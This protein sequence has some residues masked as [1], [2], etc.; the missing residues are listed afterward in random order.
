[1]PPRKG[2]KSSKP[3]RRRNASP[4]VDYK[5]VGV[6]NHLKPN[7]HFTIQHVALAL[8]YLGFFFGVDGLFDFQ[9]T[10]ALTLLNDIDVLTLLPT[11]CGKTFTF[12]AALAMADFLFNGDPRT[13]TTDPSAGPSAAE[14]PSRQP[15]L[16]PL[17]IVISPLLSLM[18]EQ[19]QTFNSLPGAKQAGLRAIHLG[20][21]EEKCTQS[22]I[23]TASII[24][25]SPEGALG[26]FKYLFERIFFKK[27]ILAVVID[28][29]HCVLHWAC[30]N[31]NVRPIG[32]AILT[33]FV[34]V[35]CWE[36]SFRGL[37]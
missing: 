26:A 25:L 32:K 1:M 9:E 8:Q 6:K 27:R 19:C 12:F 20:C 34:S 16:R 35:C 37:H 14:P 28:E 31:K 24:Y 29:A 30:L 11:G 15:F 4:V 5:T 23:K 21:D 17:M 33:C 36:Y 2:K 10:V 18:R 13:R 22:D 7:N 3:S